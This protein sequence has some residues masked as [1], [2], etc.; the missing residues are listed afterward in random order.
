MGTTLNANFATRREAAL[1]FGATD[2]IVIP[3]DLDE[4]I[5]RIR[6]RNRTRPPVTQQ[7][8]AA[9]KWWSTHEPDE[10]TPTRSW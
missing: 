9:V 7:I 4:C 1:H 6:A 10:L 5:R 8:A 3:T 2:V